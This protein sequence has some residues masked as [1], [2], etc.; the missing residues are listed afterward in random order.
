MRIPAYEVKVCQLELRPC[1][2]AFNLAGERG[3]DGAR[4]IAEIAEAMRHKRE[5][6][7]WQGK[8][9]A[10]CRNAPASSAVIRPASNRLAGS[11]SVQ[12]AG[13]GFGFLQRRFHVGPVE[14]EAWVE[15][16]EVLPRRK[17]VSRAVNDVS[18]TRVEQ[19]RF[20]L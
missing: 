13:R 12:G 10:S 9:S 4:V 16:I 14:L 17:G 8:C 19:F 2:T 3:I 15:P 18:T 5:A 6:R 7:E 1:A 20:R 11:L